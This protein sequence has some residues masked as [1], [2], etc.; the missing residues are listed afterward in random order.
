[1]C[2][3]IYSYR[4]DLRIGR[5]M[6]KSKPANSEIEYVC[7]CVRACASARALFANECQRT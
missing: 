7:V 5:R 2:V 6:G 4:S 3:G 1:M